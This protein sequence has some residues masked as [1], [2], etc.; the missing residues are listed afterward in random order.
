M[1]N[2]PV[3][4]MCP[5]CGGTMHFDGKVGKLVCDYCES[6]FTAEEIEAAYATAQASADQAARAT[7]ERAAAGQASAFDAAPKTV[8]ESMADARAATQ[9]EDA[10][11]AFL[12]RA[13]WNEQE[14]AGLRTYTC[15]SCG[16]A[17]TVDATTAVTECPYCG[18]TTVVPGALSDE[19]RPQKLIPFKLDHDQAVAALSR[20]YQGKKFLP[21]AFASSNRIAHVQ[22]VYVPFWLYD[23]GA[24][25]QGAYEAQRVRSYVSGDWQVTETAIYSVR[26]AGSLRFSQVPA[27]GSSKMPDT[28]M[29][30]IEPFDYQELT[31]FS[32]GYLPGYA[33][34]RF[35]LSARDCQA[36]VA[37]RMEN[38][39]REALRDSV[40]GYDAVTATSETA[41]V[42]WGQATYAL[43]PVWLLHTQW[44]GTDYL[45]AMNG[46]TGRLI[47][48]LPV[49][50]KKVTAWFV[51]V[52]AVACLLT[53]LFLAL[54]M[55]AD[56]DAMFVGI[57]IGVPALIAFM[58]CNMFYAE[59]KTAREKHEASAYVDGDLRLT[60]REDRYV[61]T[62]V[63]RTRIERAGGGPGKNG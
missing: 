57:L 4:S 37:E 23:A 53:Y 36:H 35:D 62:R 46:Q 30:A 21:S 45:F 26:R 56:R 7:D 9:G 27:D 43:L 52:F 59:M 33:A 44:N 41:R 50:G 32:V 12:D 10:V 31:D 2:E 1:P 25:G 39:M 51:G 15:S 47:G 28:H 55:D 16:A 20:Y 3:N 24:Q 34:E 38:S 49:D 58:V 22:G 6:A 11:H 63:S 18:S 48:D 14:R 40:T 60:Q 61:T 5:A 19:A 8:A 13:N 42:S 29:D 54:L 17:L